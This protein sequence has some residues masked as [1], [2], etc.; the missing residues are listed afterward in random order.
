VGQ[1]KSVRNEDDSLASRFEDPSNFPGT[2]RRVKKMFQAADDRDQ[3]ESPVLKGQVFASAYYHPPQAVL[4]ATR[5]NRNFRDIQA[6]RR[7]TLPL[8][9]RYQHARTA[10]HVQ[11]PLTG[12]CFEMAVHFEVKRRS[13]V[14]GR[15]SVKGIIP[16]DD[17]RQAL[18]ARPDFKHW[19]P[20]LQ[21]WS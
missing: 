14:E 16:T 3:V 12:P 13:L 18:G 19:P 4:P 20:S 21:I 6:H 8:R 5:V 15:R 2:L 1:T 10:G 11:K 17:V 7:K 9:K